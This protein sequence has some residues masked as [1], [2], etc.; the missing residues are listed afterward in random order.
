MNIKTELLRRTVS[1]IVC[2]ELEYYTEF[3]ENKIANSTA[4][5]IVGKIQE[6]LKEDKSDFDIVEEIVCLFEEYKLDAGPCH[7]FG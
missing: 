1:D 5:E 3:D 2:R 6:I 7:D 4:I